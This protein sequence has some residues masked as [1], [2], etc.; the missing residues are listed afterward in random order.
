MTLL[1]GT[2]LAACAPGDPEPAPQRA[3][4]SGGLPVVV[5]GAGIAGLAAAR[6]LADNGVEV[7]VLEA[8]DRIGGRIL[9]VPLAGA[10]VD[11]GASWVH[12]GTGSPMLPYLRRNGIALDD[13]RITDMFGAADYWDPRTGTFP[14]PALR[15]AVVAAFGELER[16][17]PAAARRSD[18]RATISATLRTTLPDV[19]DTVRSTLGAF[20]G[21]F[22]GSDA[23]GMGFASLASF[24]L[25]TGASDADMFPRG[26]YGR[27]VER[28]AD[29]LRIRTS[30]PVRA[31]SDDGA[32]VTVTTDDEAVRGSY[33]IVT[34]PLGVLKSGDVTFSPPLP[35]PV[36]DGI[37]AL[38]VGTFEKVALAYPAAPWRRAGVPGNIVVGRRDDSPQFQSFLDLGRWNDG[39]PVLLAI[40]TGEH[41]RRLA[42]MPEKERVRQAHTL[43]RSIVADLPDPLDA[44]TTAWQTDPFSVG[45]YS[46]VA[47]GSTDADAAR[48][49]A[50]FLAPQGRIRFAGE[51]TGADAIAVVDGAWTSGVREAQRI[52]GRRVR[53]T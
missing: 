51:H 34:I 40:S 24:L 27:V 39:A 52:I 48:A 18:P 44:R 33:A 42:A 26:G 20:L 9:T 2:A 30:S 37:D 28:L 10:A 41:G 31:V 53:L 5:V 49:V 35:G 46:R 8:R 1:G 3:T 15:E 22:D 7:V 25:T 13:A 32:G 17:A 19:D 38:G 6:V 23:T 21:V 47:L 45:C 4:G 12:D 11:L 43:A 29:G 14:S 36:A 50:A 16:L